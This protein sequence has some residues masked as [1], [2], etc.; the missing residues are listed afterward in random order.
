ML[1]RLRDRCL[2]LRD[3]PRLGRTYNDRDRVL[4]ERRYLIFYRIDNIVETTVV[5]T[6]V[7]HGA[8]DLSSLILR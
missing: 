4:V 6:L 1:Q 8:R 7:I 2:R 5:I 3:Q